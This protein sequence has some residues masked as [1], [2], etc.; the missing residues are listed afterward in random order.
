MTDANRAMEK[1]VRAAP[2]PL[3][4]EEDIWEGRYSGKAMYGAWIGAAGLSA[5]AVAVLVMVPDWRQSV[6]FWWGTVALLAFIWVGLLLKFCY[7]KLVH[8]YQLTSQRLK[9]REGIL[10]QTM[11]RI[12]LVDIDDIA[13]R[14]GLIQRLLQVGNITIKSKDTSHPVLVL[15]GIA[16]VRKVTDLIDNARLAERRRRAVKIESL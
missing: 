1:T 3:V 9:H 12:E 14:Q 6:A 13:Y 8:H 5:V 2:S 16:D 4:P 10:V 11:N 7:H 15:H